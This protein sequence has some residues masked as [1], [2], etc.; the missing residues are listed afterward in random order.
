MTSLRLGTRRS[1]LALAQTEWVAGRLRAAW[2]DLRVEQVPLVTEGDR[3]QERNPALAGGKGVFV[4]EIEAALLAGSIDLAVHSAKDLPTDLPAGLALL[5]VPARA[6]PRDCLVG[7]QLAH[8]P[9]GAAVGSGSPRRA[10]QLLRLRPDLRVLPMRGNVDSRVAK[11]EAGGE[12]DAALLAVSGL[13]RLGLAAAIAEALEPESFLPA[14]AQGALAVEGRAGDPALV[15][16]LAPLA[17]PAAAAEVA[18]ERAFLRGLGGG[19]AAPAAALARAGADDLTLDGL[20]VAGDDWRRERLSGP[21][22]QAEAIGRRLAERL[23]R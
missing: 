18:A 22:A 16:L 4:R 17:D 11:V 12:Y 15:R 9:R 6:D 3:S 14:P 19:C 8:L 5:C 1:R 13:T 21:R 23:A 10:L 20:Y 2:P 7:R